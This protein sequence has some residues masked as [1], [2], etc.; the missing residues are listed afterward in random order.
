MST[1]L[2]FETVRGID[3]TLGIRKSNRHDGGG[4]HRAP[5]SGVGEGLHPNYLLRY[6]DTTPADRTPFTGH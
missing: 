4:S 1:F 6:T 2:G 5:L 3:W